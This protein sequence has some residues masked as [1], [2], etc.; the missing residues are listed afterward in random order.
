MGLG[1]SE[2]VVLGHVPGTARYFDDPGRP[3]V[4]DAADTHGLKCES[5]GPGLIIL[6]PQPSDDPNDPLN[7]PL[8]RRD[9]II[10][11]LSLVAIFATALGSI[12]VPNTLTLSAWLDV[13]ITYIAVLTGYFLLAM[14]LAGFFCVPSGRLWGK[15]HLFI[16]GTCILVATTAWAG[17]AGPNYTSLLWARIIKG[18]D[19]VPFESLVNAAVGDLYFIHSLAFFDGRKTNEDFFKLLLRPLPLFIQPA[20]L[21]ACLTQGVLIGWTTFIGVT[22]GVIFLGPLLFWDEVDTGHAY[23]GPIVN[24]LA[25]FI[26]PG[27]L[28]DWSAQ[29]LTRLNRGIYEPEFHLLL[30]IPQL[31]FGCLGLYA[32]AVTAHGALDGEVHW[33]VPILFFGIEVCGMVTGTVGSSLYI[34]DA[35]RDLAVEG[36]TCLIIFKNLFTFALTFKAYDWLIVGGPE[37]IFNILATVQ[38]VVCLLSIPMYIFGKRNRSVFHRHNLLKL[39][40]LK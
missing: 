35:Y 32:F 10:F 3:W 24:A 40:G 11:I 22:I 30:V 12:L 18:V 1:I 4:I 28:A 7:W 23:T 26:I 21:W 16:I 29:Y 6:N 31:V 37:R 13:D 9:V 27:A 38:L 39:V 36:F 25:A 15:R 17:A 2:D 33:V 14:G 5:S 20:F 8:W 34:V 19:T